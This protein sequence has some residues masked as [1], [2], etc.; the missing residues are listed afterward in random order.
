M[1]MHTPLYPIRTRRSSSRGR[2]AD[3]KYTCIQHL[4]PRKQASIVRHLAMKG[5]GFRRALRF[6]PTAWRCNISELRPPTPLFPRR[7]LATSSNTPDR[8]SD[9]KAPEGS[10]TGIKIVDLSRV[11][12]VGP[13]QAVQGTKVDTHARHHIVPRFCQTMEQT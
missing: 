13:P 8:T 5:I 1:H 9:A 10:L 11:L 12:A 4:T 7:A 3:I 2:R 6:M